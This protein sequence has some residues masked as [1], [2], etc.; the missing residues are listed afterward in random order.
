MD[1]RAKSERAAAQRVSNTTRMTKTALFGVTDLEADKLLGQ[2]TD[3]SSDILLLSSPRSIE[4]RSI[5][6]LRLRLPEAIH[7]SCFIVVDAECSSCTP[8]AEQRT[9][10]VA[11]KLRSVTPSNAK[12][13]Q[14]LLV[15][16]GKASGV[17]NE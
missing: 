8:G 1:D 10:N 9:Y 4:S 13:I 15:S 14:A 6:N 5:K 7:G 12:R 17:A 16:L 2:M 3:I 11:F